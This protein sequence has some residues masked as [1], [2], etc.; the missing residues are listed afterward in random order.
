MNGHDT[1]VCALCHQE[2]PLTERHPFDSTSLCENCFE[3]KT[4]ICGSCGERIWSE[5]AES[6]GHI[7]LCLV[8]Y[9]RCYTRCTNCDR[10]IHCNDAYYVGGDVNLE[11]PYCCNCIDGVLNPKDHIMPIHL[12]S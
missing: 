5:D 9:D 6:D 10:L 4:T 7:T 2:C 11:H 3:N 8:C 12:E 1:F